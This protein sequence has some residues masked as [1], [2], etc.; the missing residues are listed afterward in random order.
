MLGSAVD[1]A[2]SVRFTTGN[3]TEV[4]DHASVSLLELTD[5]DLSQVNETE[6][7]KS[8]IVQYG[9]INHIYGS[10]PL[11]ENI[12]LMSSSAAGHLYWVSSTLQST[13]R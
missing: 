4:D 12:T 7:L 5:K 2:A 8:I 11:V 10:L 9:K 1:G 6:D 3:R 13:S